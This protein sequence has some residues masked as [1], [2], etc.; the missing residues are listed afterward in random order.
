[1]IMLV[2]SVIAGLAITIV[3][4][5]LIKSLVDT[6]MAIEKFKKTSNNLPIAESL[7][8]LGHFAQVFNGK[9]WKFAD[10][11]HKKHGKF[12]AVF[13]TKRVFVSTIDLNFIQSMIFRQQLINRTDSF[14]VPAK[15]M[16]ADSILLAKDDK[17]R[18]I[19]KCTA[20]AFS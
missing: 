7:G 16:S 13:Y 8:I 2:L 11:Q 9:N 17:W 5:D 15:E 14:G 6:R 19:R 10:E 4:A 20:P 18:R 3:F 1:M 12:C